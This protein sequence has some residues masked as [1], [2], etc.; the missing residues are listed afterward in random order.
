MIKSIKV[1]KLTFFIYFLY[2]CNINLLFLNLYIIH[3]QNN[4]M[5]KYLCARVICGFCM[6]DKIFALIIVFLITFF[7]FAIVHA[8]LFEK[9]DIKHYSKGL[10]QYKKHDYT[11]SYINFGKVSLF[12]NI[13]TPALFRQARCATLLGDV[14][15]AKRNYKLILLLHPNSQLYVVSEYNLANLLYDLKEKKARKYFMHIIKYFPETDFALASEYYVAS[16][17][18]EVAQK[19]KW[20]GKRKKLKQKSLNHFI[21]YVK[22]APTGR[23]A[24]NSIKNIT[25]LGIAITEEDSLAIADSLSERGYFV[26][27]AK[28]FSDSPIQLSWAKYAKNEYKRGNYPLAKSLTENG[29]NYFS[30]G[31]ER[32]DIY[33]AIDNY[34]SLSNMKLTTINYL[35]NTYSHADCIDY[36]LYL[37][38]KFSDESQRYVIY[39]ELY[40]KYPNS[41]FSAEALFKTFYLLIEKHNYDKAIELGKKHIAHFKQSDTS[42]AVRFWMGKIYEKQ[43]KPGLAR[44]YYKDVIERYPDSYY[45]Y[46]AYC[47]LNKNKELFIDTDIK[48]KQIEFPCSDKKQQDMASKLI[49]LGDYDFISELYKD[50]KFVESW[51]AYKKDRIVQSVIVA[52]KAMKELYPKPRFNDPKWRLVYPLNYFEYV[53]KYK[54]TQDPLMIMSIIREESHFNKNIVSPVGAVGLMQLMPATALEIARN[55]GLSVDL[56]NPKSNI[57]LGSLYYSKMKASLNNKDAYAIMAYNGGWYSV[58]QWIH[59]LNYDDLDYFIERVPYPETQSYVK[60]VLKSYW[61]YSNI[62]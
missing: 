28:Y 8:K 61:C 33:D 54:G 50:D 32:Q 40:D 49:Q 16:I 22:L 6:K 57:R 31:P 27:A 36:L 38:A 56:Y 55:Y 39:E 48:T 62:Y 47:K 45:S 29:I 14:K 24:Q 13:K 1:K 60:K 44:S 23:F 25:K 2:I 19:T 10:E 12:S 41:D 46:R 15:G 53:Y 17:D 20:Y 5:L 51:I 34:I 43:H 37:K 59:N 30:K 52:Q 26:D 58:N 42:P 9:N 3:L 18:M 21:R 11:N 4:F 7:S 35:I